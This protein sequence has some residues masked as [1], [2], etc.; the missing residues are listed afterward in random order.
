MA[1][2]LKLNSGKMRTRARGEDWEWYT[3]TVNLLVVIHAHNRTDTGRWAYVIGSLAELKSK[4]TYV[5][6]NEAYKVV[7][8]RLKILVE[9]LLAEV[10]DAQ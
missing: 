10:N 4:N 2:E 5:D 8:Q 3:A 6:K 1:I 9:D 7:I